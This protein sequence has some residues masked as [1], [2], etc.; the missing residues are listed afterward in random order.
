MQ[1]VVAR[2]D[3]RGYAPL[4]SLPIGRNQALTNA[5]RVQKPGAGEEAP[6]NA[7]YRTEIGAGGVIV[8]LRGANDKMAA[9]FLKPSPA[10][11]CL[12]FHEAE[13]VVS[14]GA[15]C[16]DSACCSAQTPIA[17][18][19]FVQTHNLVTWIRGIY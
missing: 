4:N 2:V 1:D 18:L 12:Y 14:L 6:I 19:T 7:A 10:S 16:G 17:P 9:A 15:N 5:T 11:T 13:P 3:H 8:F